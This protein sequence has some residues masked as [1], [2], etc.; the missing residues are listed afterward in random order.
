MGKNPLFGVVSSGRTS[1][2]NRGANSAPA[3]F[4]R[5]SL[6][7]TGAPVALGRNWGARATKHS[8]D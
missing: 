1:G 4:Y 6:E 2:R 7:R 8:S 3:R 5:T